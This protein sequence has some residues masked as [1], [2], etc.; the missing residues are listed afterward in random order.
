MVVA[1]QHEAQTENYANVLEVIIQYYFPT[2]NTQ[3]TIDI[4]K[5]H[6]F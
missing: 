3:Y 6:F 4:N 1:E 2:L 5:L